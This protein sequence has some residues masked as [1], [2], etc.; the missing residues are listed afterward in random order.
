MLP[1]NR[2]REMA[3]PLSGDDPK[4]EDLGAMDN[5]LDRFLDWLVDWLWRGRQGE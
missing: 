1:P 3:D 5:M 2:S 4:Y